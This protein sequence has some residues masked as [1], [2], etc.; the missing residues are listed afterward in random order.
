MSFT[1]IENWKSVT[2][3][4]IMLINLFFGVRTFQRQ[5]IDRDTLEWTVTLYREIDEQADIRPDRHM[6]VRQKNRCLVIVLW[7]QYKVGMDG[8]HKNNEFRWRIVGIMDS[9]PFSNV[10]ILPFWTFWILSKEICKYKKKLFA[11]INGSTYI[12]QFK[13]IGELN[14]R[15]KRSVSIDARGKT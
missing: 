1:L 11:R 10:T 5:P 6:N 4:K 12:D 8:H 7:N 15:V 3:L 2:R 14:E 13:Y 9:S